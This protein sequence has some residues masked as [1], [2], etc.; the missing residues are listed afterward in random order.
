MV[1]VMKQFEAVNEKC[2]LEKYNKVN[3]KL[4]K[5]RQRG[6]LLDAKLTAKNKAKSKGKKSLF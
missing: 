3:I 2:F 6:M 4:P 1:I 5:K